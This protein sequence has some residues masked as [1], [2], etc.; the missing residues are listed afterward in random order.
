MKRPS[1]STVVLVSILSLYVG[2]ALVFGRYSGYDEPWYKSAG[3][4]WGLH[5]KFAS[6]EL[7]GNLPNVDPPPEEIYFTYPPLYSILFG[8]LVRIAG[9]GWRQC[10]FYDAVIH[11]VLV[12]QVYLLSRKLSGDR[13]SSW[14]ALIPALAVLPLGIVDGRP[15]EL[16]ICF[17]L[18]GLL[19]L[20]PDR[21]TW[22]RL[23][24]SGAFFG[25]CAGTSVAGAVM[26][27]FIAFAAIVTEPRSLARILG[28]CG[29]WGFAAAVVLGLTVAPILMPYPGA[30]EQYRAIASVHIHS[31]NPL[32]RFLG[33]L[34]H[35]R[36][37]IL[38][39]S[40]TILIGLV[41]SAFTWRS[42]GTRRWLRLWLGPI[43]ALGFMFATV[44]QKANYLW[45]LIPWV[46]SAIAAELTFGRTRF[47][48]VARAAIALGLF[49]ALLL[50]VELAG[51]Y[52]IS[53]AT[54][55]PSQRPEFNQR[56]LDSTVP[57]G[58]TVLAM[59]SWWFLAGDHLVYDA[60][61][62]RVTPDMVDY[63]VLTGNGS[64]APG[65]PLDVRVRKNKDFPLNEDYEVV[66]DNLNRKP[67]MLLGRPLTNS[68]YGFGNIV[69]RRK[70]LPKPEKL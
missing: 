12:Y 50:G 41:I 70:S 31:G 54:L 5:G 16:S 58:A 64:T 60:R 62:S 56:I 25:L 61:W 35:F 2:L 33:A 4:E 52:A 20:L 3:R 67:L 66:S 47:P 42:G 39:A 28:A 46:V 10:A 44:P 17:A 57:P 9:F 69:Y 1:G 55:P 13:L 63:V 11:V 65:V 43:L 38:S 23:A 37:M 36:H 32:S 30:I 21:Q 24:L 68:A 34:Q 49:C 19:V 18:A 22:P 26:L 8:V 59:D 51:K 29:L 15:D 14:K 6:P 27:G 45:F 7:T 40:L 53:L 48:R